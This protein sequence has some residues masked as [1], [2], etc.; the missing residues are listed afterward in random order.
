VS[1]V[2]LRPSWKEQAGEARDAAAAS[3]R[4]Q[5]TDPSALSFAELTEIPATLALPIRIQITVPPTAWPWAF[6]QRLIGLAGCLALLPIF[7]LMY[8][9]VRATSRGPFL[10]AQLRPGHLGK[11]FRAYKVRTMSVGAE[12]KTTLGTSRRDKQITRIGRL[13]RELKLDELPQLWNIARGEMELVGPRPLPLALDEELRK[14]ISNFD[15]RYRVKPGLTNVSQVVVLDNKL[16]DRLVEDWKLRFE[17]EL[18]YIKNKSFAYDL[19]VLAMTLMFV[20][21]KL[22]ATVGARLRRIIP[23]IT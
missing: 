6:A 5:S 8:L 16:G 15:L 7:V 1:S 17:G 4:V 21:R 23:T 9:V 2:P 14:H 11:P 18:H 3:P 20:L 19:V 12:Q 13:L 10:F 22:G